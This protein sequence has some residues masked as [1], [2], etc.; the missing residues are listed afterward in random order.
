M[1]RTARYQV[2]EPQPLRG[3][4]AEYDTMPT[5]H[6][7]MSPREPHENRP[8][9]RRI[10]GPTEPAIS[11][12][13]T[14]VRA[15]IR[16]DSSYSFPVFDLGDDLSSS[17]RNVTTPD[18]PSF[19]ITT[20]YSDNSGGE[21]EESSATTLADRYHRDSLPVR[22]ASSEEDTEDGNLSRGAISRARAFGLPQSQRRSRRRANPSMIEIA[23]PSIDGN[24]NNQDEKPSGSAEVLAPHA[25]FFIDQHKSMI[26]IKFD[27]LV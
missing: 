9:S 17:L 3:T 22:Y 13:I 24:Q 25:R 11:S 27:P 21:E 2:R 18:L 4:S 26:S 7:T 20:D 6:Q 12:P 19:T 14:D 15:F 23:A 5:L 1:T 16:D 10:D 8:P